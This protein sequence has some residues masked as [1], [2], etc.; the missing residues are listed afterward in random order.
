MDPDELSF[1][2]P[3][4]DGQPTAE[5]NPTQDDTTTEA[6]P[7]ATTEDTQP[8]VDDGFLR[9][10]RKQ[11][12]K[13]IARL[14]RDDPEF[15]NVLNSYVGQKARAKYQPRIDELSH[16]VQSLRHREAGSQFTNLP[17]EELGK[18]IAADPNFARDYAAFASA[19]APALANEAVRYRM[20]FENMLDTALNDGLTS[21]RAESFRQEVASG[22]YDVDPSGQ[23][24]TDLSTAMWLIQRDLMREVHGATAPAPPTT[25]TR[26]N[27]TQPA[28]RD[29]ASPDLTSAARSTTGA[30]ISWDE[31]KSM[32]P[33]R[34]LDMFPGDDDLNNALRSGRII[35]APA[36]ALEAIA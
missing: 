24:I 22:K 7:A 15:A 13:E 25:P 23:P 31:V 26:P 28:V 16:E 12:G 9:L 29:T 30:K 6:A 20:Q 1:N 10:D 18:R 3:P 33:D 32:T 35:G 8:P 2:T 17:P 34:L 27:P 5:W 36:E 19:P 21:E 14:Q 4:D 11:L